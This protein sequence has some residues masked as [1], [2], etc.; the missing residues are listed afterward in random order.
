MILYHCN[1]GYP[2][3]S[4]DS[5]MTSSAVQVEPRDP[6]AAE[7][8]DTW[9][10]MTEPEADFPEQVYW[11]RLDGTQPA[12]SAAIYNQALGLGMA[13]DFNPRELTHLTEWKQMGFGDYTIGIEPGNCSPIGRVAAREDGSLR[14]L[15]PGETD[16]FHL[17]FR[18]IHE[19][20]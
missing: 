7:N 6:R 20:P 10:L 18:M 11:H 5:I 19:A 1:F 4:P 15:P 13:V 2:I 16:S 14:M 3:V 9:H 12:A 8:L 17:T